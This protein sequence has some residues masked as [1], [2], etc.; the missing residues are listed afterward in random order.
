VFALRKDSDFLFEN[1]GGEINRL[2]MNPA[3]RSA[4]AKRIFPHTGCNRIFGVSKNAS[5]GVYLYVALSYGLDPC[6]IYRAA[7]VNT[8]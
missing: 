8:M 6:T 3:M 1:P 7:S 5:N 2:I 4:H